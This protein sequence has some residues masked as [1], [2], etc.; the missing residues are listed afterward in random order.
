VVV[1]L[2]VQLALS[3]FSRADYLFTKTAANPSGVYPSDVLQMQYVLFLPYW[4]WGFGCGAFAVMA[5]LYG[6]RTFWG[7]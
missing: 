4:F 6:I 2:A 5:L 3:V 1:F 7:R